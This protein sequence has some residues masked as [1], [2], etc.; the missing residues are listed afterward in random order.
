MATGLLG[1]YSI[2]DFL[3]N[4]ASPVFTDIGILFSYI[5]ISNLNCSLIKSTDCS[6]VFNISFDKIVLLFNI[7]TSIPSIFISGLILFLMLFILLISKAKP[8]ADRYSGLTGISTLSQAVKAF[9]VSIPRLGEQSII[10]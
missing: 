7:V 2:T 4:I 8:F 1:L 5:C 9:I 6:K 10:I 3:F